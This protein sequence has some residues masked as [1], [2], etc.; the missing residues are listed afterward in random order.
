MKNGIWVFDMN[1]NSSKTNISLTVLFITAYPAGRVFGCLQYVG[2]RKWSTPMVVKYQDTCMLFFSWQ[3]SYFTRTEPSNQYQTPGNVKNRW[4][5][6]LEPQQVAGKET[7]TLYLYCWRCWTKVQIETHWGLSVYIIVYLST[8]SY[9]FALATD[10]QRVHLGLKGRVV[11]FCKPT[12]RQRTTTYF[13]WPFL[14]SYHLSESSLISFVV[15]LPLYFP[16]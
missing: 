11:Y 9:I 6:L 15:K 14:D 5:G 7:G 2:P 1:G 8:S 12:S 16:P 3:S 10:Y 13:L 4:A